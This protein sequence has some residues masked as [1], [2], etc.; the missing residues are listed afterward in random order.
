MRYK[1]NILSGFWFFCSVVHFILGVVAAVTADNIAVLICSGII[2]CGA[3]FFAFIGWT[4][5]RFLEVTVRELS[6]QQLIES[7]DA[8]RSLTRSRPLADQ[9]GSDERYQQG[10]LR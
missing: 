3:A 1:F 2:I 4:T 10:G 9:D 7:L 5:G 8:M 6:P